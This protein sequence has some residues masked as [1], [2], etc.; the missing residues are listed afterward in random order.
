MA[1]KI[2]YYCGESEIQDPEPAES[3]EQARRMIDLKL[4]D[5]A[6]KAEVAMILGISPSGT[7]EL[8]ETRKLHS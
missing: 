2:R 3:L 5:I 1:F 4:A 8:V 6:C 7:E